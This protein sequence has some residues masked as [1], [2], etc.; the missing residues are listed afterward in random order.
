MTS[1]VIKP[2]ICILNDREVRICNKVINMLWNVVEFYKMYSEN[3]TNGPR[4]H[5]CIG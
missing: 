2:T 3:N 5:E 4:L 1:V